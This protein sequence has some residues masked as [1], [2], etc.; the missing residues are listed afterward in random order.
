MLALLLTLKGQKKSDE[1]S[2]IGGY[3]IFLERNG[4]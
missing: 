2:L 3:I 1:V 4:F